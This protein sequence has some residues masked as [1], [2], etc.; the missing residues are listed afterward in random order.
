METS[1]GGS[2]TIIMRSAE[3]PWTDTYEAAPEFKYSF[4]SF[5]PI[6]S[7]YLVSVTGDVNPEKL[8]VHFRGLG[9]SA[10]EAFWD[11]QHQHRL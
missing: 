2:T 4:Q 7:P 11:S 1:E 6:K 8:K 5:L 3:N 10:K 9:G